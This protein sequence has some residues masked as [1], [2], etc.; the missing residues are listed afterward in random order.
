MACEGKV[1]LMFCEVWDTFSTD[2]VFPRA[3]HCR[4]IGELWQIT[5][6]ADDLVSHRICHIK[7]FV[8]T[9]VRHLFI[10]YCVSTYL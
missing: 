9:Q 8:K 4:E 1:I 3:I 2:D 10:A 6:T 5:N 7:V